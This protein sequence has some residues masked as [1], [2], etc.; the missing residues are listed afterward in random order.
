MRRGNAQKLPT[1]QYTVYTHTHT[2]THTHAHI[3]THTHT[4]FLSPCLPRVPLAHSPM[5]TRLPMQRADSVMSVRSR[6]SHP[7]SLSPRERGRERERERGRERETER[8][9]VEDWMLSWLYK[10]ESTPN[11]Y[12]IMPI[13]VTMCFGSGRLACYQVVWLS[14]TGEI[15]LEH[16]CRC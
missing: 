10:A 6:D 16:N 3:R 12:I 8:E 2:H 7:P 4:L 15:W 13:K 14:R 5:L 11:E 9:K 1:G